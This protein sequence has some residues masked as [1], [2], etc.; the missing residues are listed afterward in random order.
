MERW[1]RATENLADLSSRLADSGNLGEAI[2]QPIGLTAELS[3][4]GALIHLGMSPDDLTRKP[5]GHGYQTL[6]EKLVQ[7]CPHRDD[8]EVL[9]VIAKLP[10]MVG[11][12][13]DITGL[14]RLQVIELALGVQFVA[15]ST[16]RRVSSYD[17]AKEMEAAAPRPAFFT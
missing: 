3:L 17:L 6:A 13:Y 5:Y 4:K 8:P 9:R 14:T 12:P 1:V 7:L 10:Q 16:V 11:S 15:A 2:L